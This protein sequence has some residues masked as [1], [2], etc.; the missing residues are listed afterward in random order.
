AFS[1]RSRE[2][3]AGLGCEWVL[4]N[5][6]TKMHRERVGWLG[7]PLIARDSI[8][9]H[10]E[11]DDPDGAVDLAL[12]A[13]EPS[14]LWSALRRAGVLPG[15]RRHPAEGGLGGPAAHRAAPAGVRR[16]ARCR[17]YCRRTDHALIALL[18]MIGLRVSEACH[19][20]ITDL[21]YQG[22]YEILHVLGLR[23]SLR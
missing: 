23:G 20:S 15:R 1:G 6:N 2:L 5:S 17:S 18:G 21:R 10:N 14:D 9:L 3:G 7:T 16:V 12:A 19:A 11:A 8:V 4:K 13:K 22:G